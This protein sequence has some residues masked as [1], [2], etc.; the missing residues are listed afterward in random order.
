[1]I[2]V[3]KTS[4]GY[5]KN[6]VLDNLSFEINDGGV[7]GI[8]GPNGSG[9]T[10][11]LKVLAG[12]LPYKGNIHIDDA[13]LGSMK[14][15]D[16]S[17][18]IAMMPQ[19]ST[20]Y[21]SYSVYDTVM[22]GRYVH[23]GNSL[24]ELIGNTSKEDKEI[25]EKALETTGL[26]DLAK[27]ELKTL[28]GG[29]L[30]RVYLARTIA[31]GAPAILLDEPTNHLDLKFHI[32]LMDY[33]KKWSKE[34]TTVDGTEYKNTV[35]TVF[36]D[37]GAA[38]MISDNVILLKH[39]TIIKKGPSSETLTRNLLENIYETDVVSYYSSISDKLTK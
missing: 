17:K 35:I 10:T 37:I 26:T 2:K 7:V 24:G 22:L 25:V 34:T 39:G 1:M 29:Q 15:R 12:I 5:D 36:H 30:Q 27:A 20:I 3:E 13:E 23:R 11:L 4:A 21:F 18:R 32:E 28:S 31:Q 38:S 14:R 8:L 6:I 16:L 19:F 9:K 33:L